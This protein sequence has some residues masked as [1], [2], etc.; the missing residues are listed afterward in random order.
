MDQADPDEAVK[1]IAMYI[2]CSIRGAFCLSSGKNMAVFKGSGWAEEIA[3]FYR[4]KEIKA[5][6]W[7][8]HSRFPTNTPGVVG[9]GRIHS[10][11]S[12][13]QWSTTEK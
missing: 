12:D 10:R 6:M 11:S 8:A 4:I 1:D 5:Y 3:D 7:S 13:T 9:R 2:N